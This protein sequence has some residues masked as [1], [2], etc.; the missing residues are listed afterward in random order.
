MSRRPKNRRST[1]RCW[2]CKIEKLL[3]RPTRQEQLA[4]L[5]EKE[6]RDDAH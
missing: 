2:M 1:N 5:A 4:A 3:T 6:Q